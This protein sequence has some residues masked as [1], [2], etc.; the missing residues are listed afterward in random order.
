MNFT[1]GPLLQ[2]IILALSVVVGV[3]S[4]VFYM[5]YK[6]RLAGNVLEGPTAKE[7]KDRF[8]ILG[9]LYVLVALLVVLDAYATMGPMSLVIVLIVVGGGVYNLMLINKKDVYDLADVNFLKWNSIILLIIA[10]IYLIT[11]K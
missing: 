2:I 5:Q 8:N 6:K 9:I 11:I 3:V 7:Y 4:F 1:G 10:V